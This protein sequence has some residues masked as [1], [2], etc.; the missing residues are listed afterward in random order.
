MS[1]FLSKK[2]SGRL[3]GVDMVEKEDLDLVSQNGGVGGSRRPC[4][5]QKCTR[6]YLRLLVF[7]TGSLEWCVVHMYMHVHI[8]MYVIVILAF[9]FQSLL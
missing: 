6:T 2:L 3:A 1:S 8:Y 5:R 4:P 9:S 7:L